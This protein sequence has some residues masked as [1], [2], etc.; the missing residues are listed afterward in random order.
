MRYFLLLLLIQIYTKSAGQVNIPID[1]WRSHFSYNK[2]LKVYDFES[3]TYVVSENG[4]FYYDKSDGSV[5]TLSKING[6]SE[7]NISALGYNSSSQQLI[8]GY[9]SG[10]L[11]VVTNNEIQFFDLNTN[12]QILGSKRINHILVVASR[13][14]I[15]TDYGLLNFNLLKLEITETYR[16]LGAGAVQLGVNQSVVFGD[17]IYLASKAGIIASNYKS[18]VNLLDPTSWNRQLIT[19]DISYIS[20]YKNSILCAIDMDGMYQ[21]QNSA[22]VKIPVLENSA[23]S[24]LNTDSDNISL[25]SDN[26]IYL[27]D[28][29]LNVTAVSSNLISNPQDVDIG[30]GTVWIA[31]ELNGLVTNIS[32]DYSVIL[33]SG[34]NTNVVFNLYSQGLNLIALPGGYDALRQPNNVTSGFNV[35]ER[36]NWNSFTEAKS[37]IPK[38]NDITDATYFNDT[39]SYYFSSYGNGVLRLTNAGEKIIYNDQNSTLTKTTTDENSI[40]ITSLVNSSEG[41]WVANYNGAQGIHLFNGLGWQSFSIPTTKIIKL[42]NSANY[43]W[44]VVDSNFG[45]GVLVF[46]KNTGETRYLT[47]ITGNGGLPSKTVNALDIDDDG[48]VWIGTNSGVAT[49]SQFQNVIS[50]PVDAV[51]PIFENRLLLRDEDIRSIKIDAGNRKWIGTTNG[52]WLF[53]ENIDAELHF[54]NTENSP[55]PSNLISSIEII[56]ATGEV[57]FATPEGIVSFR[58]DATVAESAHQLV[59]IFPNPV[60]PDYSGTVGISG[61]ADNVKI[62]ITDASGRLIWDTRSSGG[63]AVWSATDYNGRRAATGV[64]FVFSSTDDGSETFIGKIAVVN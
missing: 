27:I 12:S 23:I 63:T 42:V 43:I 31:D 6:L 21:Y 15:S 9:S 49:I 16:Q 54:F 7:D 58:S 37:D 22:W 50:E 35:F 28:Q 18:G 8:I 20:S 14:F 3:L 47:D 5:T 44:M 60:T 11:E 62:K 38:F 51:V 10:N 57:F 29:A 55:L 2:S 13:A 19:E 56:G 61:L 64:Y 53:D 34:P 17:S 39:Q 52:V 59:K 1:T 33:P 24:S 25:I 45:G 36:G 40:Y 26:Q 30:Q 4:L 48:L 32:G 46:E 41:L